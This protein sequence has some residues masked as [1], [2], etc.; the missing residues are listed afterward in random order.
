LGAVHVAFVERSLGSFEQGGS[1][2]Q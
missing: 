1:F 2:C